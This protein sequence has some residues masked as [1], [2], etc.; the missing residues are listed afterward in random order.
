MTARHRDFPAGP[1]EF[2]EANQTV[3]R[4]T[5]CAEVDWRC[6]LRDGPSL[7]LSFFV[8]SLSCSCTLAQV[9]SL[10]SL[11]L[12]TSSRL[13]AL[14]SDRAE[15]PSLEERRNVGYWYRLV[16]RNFV[17][18]FEMVLQSFRPEYTTD[19]G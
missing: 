2:A 8:S 5:E 3:P 12:Y 11:R 4:G 1:V 7:L 10:L 16:A 9:F 19:A 18:R 17:L 6:G 13:F 15:N 14:P